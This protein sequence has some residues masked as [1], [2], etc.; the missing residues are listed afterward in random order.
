VKVPGVTTI[1]GEALRARALENWAAEVTAETA[2]NHWEELSALPL[3]ERLT[4]LKRARWDTMTRAALRGTQI[5][6]LAWRLVTG[7]PVEVPDEH[8]G[9][10]Q[11]VARFMDA[12]HLEPVLRERPVVNM[13]H[14]W[15][16]TIDLLAGIGDT[17]WL[18]DWK[19]GKGIYSETALQLSA[20]AH[21][22]W[23]EREDGTLIEWTPPERAGAVHITP[24]S[25]EL[26]EVDA[27]DETYMAF[28]YCQQV[29]RWTE[30]VSAAREDG[31]P[32]PIGPAL[33]PSAGVSVA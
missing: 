11:A 16:G 4:V 5:H 3:T 25:A 6:D 1:L 12:H 22:E 19:T 32:W 20:Y 14:R 2:V 24:D 31:Q 18:L 8:L 23:A 29:A 27:G 28:R 26:H 13:T 21:A 30:R 17:L 7:E 10:V 33:D 9:P 15:A